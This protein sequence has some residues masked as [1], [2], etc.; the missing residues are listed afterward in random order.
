MAVAAAPARS[1]APGSPERLG[2]LGGTFDPPHIGHLAAA[3]ACRRALDLDRV[4]LVV[5]NDPWQK[6][7]VRPVSPA[8]DRLAMTQAACA[9]E[10]GLEVSDM[11]IDRGGPSYTVDTVEALRARAA[12]DGRPAPEI[13]L[14]VG[15]DLVGTLPT[16]HRAEALRGLVTLAVV[17]RPHSPAAPVPP[18]WDAVSVDDVAVDVSSSEVRALLGRGAPVDAVVPKAVIRCIERRGLYAVGR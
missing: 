3:R 8:A 13:F 16:W 9:G 5:A 1:R 2:L 10:P 12:A 18:G 15:A 7:P 6:A 17:G 11:E 4:L 14:I